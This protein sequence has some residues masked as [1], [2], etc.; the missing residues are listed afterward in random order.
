MPFFLK[1]AVSL[2]VIITCAQIGKRYP[3]LGGLIATMPLTTL[4]VMLWMRADQPS[5]N[6]IMTR[7]TTGVLWGIGPTILFFLAL[8][9]CF[10][11]NL[12]F[13]V[14]LLIAATAWLA[15][16]VIHQKFLH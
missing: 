1:A 14:S 10:Q 8:R 11:R 2:A 12:G 15:G 9:F 5:D 13:G 16:A 6:A 4:L 3:T 7:Y